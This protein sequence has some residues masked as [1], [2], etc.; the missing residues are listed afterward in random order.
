MISCSPSAGIGVHHGPESPFT[1]TGIGVH[2]RRIH[3]SLSTGIRTLFGQLKGPLGNVP[4]S[5]GFPRTVVNT[6]DKHGLGCFI[7]SEDHAVGMMEDGTIRNL[8]I[9]GLRYNGVP[10]WHFAQ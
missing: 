5:E 8:E 9:V 6:D 7:N 4:G 10:A 1:I 2:L 3:C